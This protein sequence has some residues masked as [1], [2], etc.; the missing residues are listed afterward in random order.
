MD[1]DQTIL[2]IIKRHN[3]NNQA[4][5]Q[6]LLSQQGHR[7]NQSTLSRRLK[8]LNV[9]KLKGYYREIDQNGSHFPPCTIVQ[10]A[11]NLIIIR[12]T[13]GF[14]QPMA[15]HI[16]QTQTEG[17]IG[18]VAG[19]DTVLVVVQQSRLERVSE[20]LQKILEQKIE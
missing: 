4:V 13:S 19:D 7:L 3:I 16:D 1:I 15:V 2:K 14:A 11:P 5:L 17:I 12:T 10:A 20:E 6:E 8:K 18:T 9:Q